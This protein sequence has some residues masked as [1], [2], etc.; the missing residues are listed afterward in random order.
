M[1]T[2]PTNHEVGAIRLRGVLGS[3]SSQVRGLL[4]LKISDDASAILLGA[5]EGTTWPAVVDAGLHAAPGRTILWHATTRGDHSPKLSDRW[6]AFG[7]HPGLIDQGAPR[8]EMT[9]QFPGQTIYSDVAWLELNGGDEVVTLLSPPSTGADVAL[10]TFKEPD[11]AIQKAW[12]GA[13]LGLCWL[14]FNRATVGQRPVES[15]TAA[16]TLLTF[17]RATIRLGGVA[18]LV[19]PSEDAGHLLWLAGNHSAIA[20]AKRK[21]DSTATVAWL[22][23]LGELSRLWSLGLL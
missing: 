5:D 17:L 21:I 7:R 15:P 11:P 4:D 3:L 1:R 19:M 9:L 2:S 20:A 6:R 23:D 10:A 22:R 18:L 16:Y 14:W 8:V 12:A 13:A